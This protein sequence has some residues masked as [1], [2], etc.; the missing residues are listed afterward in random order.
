MAQDLEIDIPL[1]SG[2]TQ[3]CSDRGTRVCRRTGNC[4]RARGGFSLIELMVVVMI[5]LVLAAIAIPNIM[6]TIS[7]VRLRSAA[8]SVAGLLQEGRMRA[9][10][11]NKSYR[12]FGYT[13]DGTVGTAD[14]QMACLD[15]ENT[16]TCSNTSD[17]TNRSNPQVQLGGVNVLTTAAPPSSVKSTAGFGSNNDVIEQDKNLQVYFNSRGLPC[18]MSGSLCKNTDSTGMGYAYIYYITDQ[19]PIYG[20]AAITVSSAGRVRVWM[21]QG[22]SKWE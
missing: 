22:N 18:A 11:D 14:T 17:P 21:Y 15:L 13:T 9:I 1:G 7:D 8:N 5:L 2:G 10:R 12:V 19:R 4:R 20:W 3:M 6:K 16:A